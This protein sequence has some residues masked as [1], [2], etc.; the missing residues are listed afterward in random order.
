MPPDYRIPNRPLVRHMSRKARVA[1]PRRFEVELMIAIV[2]TVITAVTMTRMW[3]ACWV[4][5]KRPTDLVL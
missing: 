5:R 3:V 2:T 4:R 1:L